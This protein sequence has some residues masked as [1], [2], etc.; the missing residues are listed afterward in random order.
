M[1]CCF[2]LICE[3]WNTI[4][5]YCLNGSLLLELLK[6]WDIRYAQ[7]WCMFCACDR[8]LNQGPIANRLLGPFFSFSFPLSLS[9]SQD[10]HMLV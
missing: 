5:V 4:S 10:G 7:A 3:G 6:T 9:L 8:I 2:I 1:V